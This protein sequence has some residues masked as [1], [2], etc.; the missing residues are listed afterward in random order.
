LITLAFNAASQSSNPPWWGVPVLAGIFTILG[1]ALSQ[2][3]TLFIDRARWKR[4]NVT[5][6]HV[7]RLRVY[8]ELLLAL[9]KIYDALTGDTGP[10]IEPE[11]VF[12]AVQPAATTARLVASPDV[13]KAIWD[14]L[15]GLAE[16]ADRGWGGDRSPSMEEMAKRFTKLRKLMR[17]ELGVPPHGGGPFLTDDRPAP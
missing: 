10:P 2:T 1:A 17:A 13:D 11:E 9:D 4:D 8:S 16:V 5:R 12:D 3:A 6:W 14:T 7:D 15:T